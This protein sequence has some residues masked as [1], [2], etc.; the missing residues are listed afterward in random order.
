MGIGSGAG[1][2]ASD[3]AGQSKPEEREAFSIGEDFDL[4][5][6]ASDAATLG[7]QGLVKGSVAPEEKE[8]A[9]IT[10]GA[11][12]DDLTDGPEQGLVEGALSIGKLG[13]FAR[14]LAAVFTGGASLGFTESLAVSIGAGKLGDKADKLAG[15]AAIV[16]PDTVGA[17]GIVSSIDTAIEE[18]L[19]AVESFITP[20]ETAANAGADPDGSKEEAGASTAAPPLRQ[21]QTPSASR[22]HVDV[23]SLPSAIGPQKRTPFMSAFSE[24]R[25]GQSPASVAG[26]F[27]GDFDGNGGGGDTPAA[28]AASNVVPISS[29]VDTPEEETAGTPA[30]RR[31]IPAARRTFLDDA[32]DEANARKS[33]VG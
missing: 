8:A 32:E 6:E 20:E 29:P 22:P 26:D 11:G 5:G 9:G 17:G 23:R 19:Q 16:T 2:E 21:Q 24:D 14:A 31:F 30:P 27:G 28:E 13:L 1:S 7:Q 3:L 12:D 25:G 15:N 4:A 18:G 10:G 33:L